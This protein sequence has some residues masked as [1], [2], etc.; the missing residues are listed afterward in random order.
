VLYA[1]GAI[2]NV[3]L[4][5]MQHVAA[6]R[7]EGGPFRDIFDFV[8]RVDPGRSTSAPSRPWRGPAPS[9]RSIRTGA[10]GGAADAWSATA[11]RGA[12]DRLGAG[13]LFGGRP[14]AGARARDARAEPWTPTERLDEELA[15]V[16][17]YLSGHPLDDMVEALR[18]KRTDLLTDAIAK[19]IAG[20]EAL[21]MAG[22]VR[23]KQERPVR[24]AR[25]SP[26]SPSPTHRR[27][28]GAVP[29]GV[30]AQVPRPAGAG[31]GAVDQGARQGQRR[32]G[33]LLR[34]R[35]G[36]GGEGG[37]ERG[38]GLRVHVPA[39]A[40][41]EALKK[42]LGRPNGRG[43]EVVLSRPRTAAARWS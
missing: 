18:R 12:R 34:R 26:S 25:S 29:A 28:R 41:I 15:A 14:T 10:A 27:V 3:G 36:A 16:G 2:R 24:T 38:R 9:T 13:R 33:A 17:F 42:R 19:A 7:R 11:R 31:Q 22:V 21:R 20:A 37:R 4:Q 43:G 8:E 40:E 6:V 23:R 1:L 32:R 30:A 35:R 39:S 5:A